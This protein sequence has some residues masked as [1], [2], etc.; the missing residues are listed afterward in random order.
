MSFNKVA[1]VTGANKGIGFEIV[2]GLC[3]KFNGDVYLTSRNKDRGLKAVKKLQDDGVN[4]NYHQLDI[5][6]K[7]SISK[8]SS[9][10]LDKYGGVDVLVNNVGIML[11]KNKPGL[12]IEKEH[13]FETNFFGTCDVST[14]FLLHMKN[15]LF[16]VYHTKMGESR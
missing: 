14:A 15:L 16:S 1:F 2:K 10:M 6:S 12:L 11:G 13:T 7:E 4:V 3:A 5:T 9:Y 8:L